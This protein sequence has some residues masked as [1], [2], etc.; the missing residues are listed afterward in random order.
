[1][2]SRPCAP[3]VLM[4]MP[5]R[6]RYEHFGSIA[7]ASGVCHTIGAA[8]GPIGAGRIYDLTGS[9]SYAL[10]LFVTA[11]ILGA[12]ATLASFS[13]ESEQSRPMSVAITAP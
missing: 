7:G 10:D 11:C 5:K 1:M 8:I 13:P 4:P 12:L 6:L 9:Y 3:L 2:A